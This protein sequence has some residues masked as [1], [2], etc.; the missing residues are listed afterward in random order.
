MFQHRQWPEGF[1][2]PSCDNC[3]HGTSDPD[4]VVSMMARMDPFTESGNQDGRLEGL[5][6]AV[7]KQYPGIFEKMM[8]SPNEARRNN[9]AIN[10]QPAP[11]QTHQETG[12]VKIP[13]EIHDAVCIFSRKLAKAIYYLE[14]HAIFPNEGCL[15]LN[16]FTNADFIR[17]GKYIVFDSLSELGGSSP[18]LQRSGKFL[19]NQFE[20]K[21][22]MSAD[23]AFFVLQSRFSNSFG[24]VMFGSVIPGKLEG[25]VEKLREQTK[26]NGPFAVLQSTSLT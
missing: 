15:L 18:P 26:K 3:N 7:N 24:L 2:F 9:K 13:P 25:M 8:P 17:D 23:K 16:W 20:Y 5:M 12:S 6:F 19:N 21:V 10:I 14:T 1:E 4:L 11:G 22:S